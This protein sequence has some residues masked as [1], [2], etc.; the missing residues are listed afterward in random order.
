VPAGAE[1]LD[2][3]KAAL[4]QTLVERNVVTWGEMTRHL[5]EISLS[6]DFLP[7]EVVPRD[8]GYSLCVDGVNRAVRS[9]LEALRAEGDRLDGFFGASE[10]FQALAPAP[11]RPQWTS[12]CAAVDLHNVKVVFAVQIDKCLFK[13]NFILIT[14]SLDDPFNILNQG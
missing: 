12:A 8:D 13:I 2:P 5:H 14:K 10:K 1:D 4:R 9:S 3:T 7:H 6:L 11:W